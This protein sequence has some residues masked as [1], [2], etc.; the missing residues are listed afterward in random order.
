M[1]QASPLNPRNCGFFIG[2]SFLVPDREII[3]AKPWDYQMIRRRSGRALALS[4]RQQGKNAIA[5]YIPS[6]L[7]VKR[8]AGAALLLSL[9]VSL[10]VNDANLESSKYDIYL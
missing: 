6:L 2:F 4:L 8:Q 7:C 9:M 10:L 5:E 1:L 3:N